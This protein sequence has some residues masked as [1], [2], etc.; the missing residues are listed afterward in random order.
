MVMAKAGDWDRVWRIGGL[1]GGICQDA[2]DGLR[3]CLIFYTVYLHH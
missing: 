1:E 2:E 3:G